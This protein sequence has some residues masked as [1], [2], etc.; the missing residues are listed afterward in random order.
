MNRKFVVGIL[1]FLGLA[2]L[3]ACSTVMEMVESEPE[4]CD[5]AGALFQ[6]DFTEEKDCGWATY[7][8]GGAVVEK[9]DGVMR[10]TTSQPGQIWW[11]N[12]GKNFGDVVITTQVTNTSGPEDNAYGVICRYQGEEN[13][14]LFLISSD[15]YY[16]I[17]KY[18]AG[19][20][21]VSYLPEDGQF[22]QS[23]FINQGTGAVN[24]I[25]ASCVGNQ[26]SLS[27]NGQPLL[28][29]TDTTFVNGDVGLAAS[30]FQP[31][32]AVFDFDDFRV[33]TP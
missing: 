20:D 30:T 13:Y 28:T 17:G 27:V 1:L 33:T 10:L 32:T 11:T 9:I 14:Y 31:G 24:D 5:G 3:P 19:T 2:L 18:Q 6:D 29:V 21:R 22:G 25:R 15:G 4:T 7:N 12:P 23:E 8:R 26:L 16:A